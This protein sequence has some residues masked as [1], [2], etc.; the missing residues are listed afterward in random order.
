MWA[1]RGADSTSFYTLCGNKLKFREKDCFNFRCSLIINET[2]Y[3]TELNLFFL[4][5]IHITIFTMWEQEEKPLTLPWVNDTPL[6]AESKEELQGLLI[7]M[8]E[9][10]KNTRLKPS[11][12]KTKIMVFS[13]ITSWQIEGEKVETV[14]D[15]SSCP[16]TT[17]QMVTVAM[18]LEDAYSLEEKKQT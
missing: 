14:E 9:E 16:P 12:Q 11:I 1:K 13:G 5:E 15:L 17:L 7:K 8:E 18:K 10:R 6:M 2:G 3:V 4:L